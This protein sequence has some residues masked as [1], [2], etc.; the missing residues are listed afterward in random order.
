MNTQGLPRVLNI[1]ISHYAAEKELA[2]AWKKLLEEI[3]RG[4]IRVWYSSDQNPEGGVPIGD[5]RNHLYERLKQ[6]DIVLALQTRVSAGRPWI[7]WECG[8]ASG[9]ERVRHIIPILYSIKRGRL[10]NPIGDYQSFEGDNEEQVRELCNRLLVEEAG[11]RTPTRGD[12]T[13]RIKSYM[14]AIKLYGPQQ[15]Q[16]SPEEDNITYWRE[17]LVRFVNEGRADELSGQRQAMYVSLP[18]KPLSLPI[19]E[20]LSL[21]L[22]QQKK[23]AEALEEVDFGLKLSPKNI[24]LLHRKALILLGAERYTEAQK[25]IEEIITLDPKLGV[26]PEIAGLQGRLHRELWTRTKKIG[27]LDAAIDAYL[28][29]YTAEPTAY[30]PGSNAAE[31]LIIKGRVVEGEEIFQRVLTTCQQLQAQSSGAFWIDFTAGEAFFA[32]GD[33]DN[34]VAEYRNG[35]Q[36]TSAPGKRERESAFGSIERLA[37]AL[38]YPP[39][40]VERIKDVL[41]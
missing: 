34:A 38:H 24:V 21:Y 22:H 25:P 36:R 31:L 27:E 18:K 9:V 41:M 7:M 28:R 19:H 1:F 11:L 39:E 10:E 35:R 6:C 16:A 3:S 30:Y 15:Q 2:T 40:F 26:N 32:L 4:M 33:I 29:A 8:V 37:D 5:W 14:S 13:P 17:H 23:F 20:L 12:L